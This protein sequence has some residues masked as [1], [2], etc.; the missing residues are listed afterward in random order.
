LPDAGH[1]RGDAVDAV[2]VDAAKVG[3]D[4]GFGYDE[5]VGR[6][7]AV[8]FEDGLDEGLGRGRGDVEFRGC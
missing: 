7:D 8:A 1:V 6:R 4:E 3:E 2:G 5:S